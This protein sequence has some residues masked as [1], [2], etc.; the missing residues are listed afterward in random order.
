MN[1][2]W[3]K[4]VVGAAGI[5]GGLLFFGSAAANAAIPV[6]GE[7]LSAQ[8]VVQ[9][10]AGLVRP[11]GLQHVGD[12]FQ[13]LASA[14]RAESDLDAV[15]PALGNPPTNGMRVNVPQ[16]ANRAGDQVSQQ[17][18]PV[19]QK[20][21]QPVDNTLGKLP[22]DGGLPLTVAAGTT[23]DTAPT[24]STGATAPTAPTAPTGDTGATGAT[25]PAPASPIG[26]LTG[27]LT[28][29]SSPLGGLASSDGVAND[30]SVPEAR[31]TAL[32][33]SA[34]SRVLPLSVPEDFAVARGTQL[35]VSGLGSD[36][37]SL[38]TTVN[39]T[40]DQRGSMPAGS[41]PTA[42]SAQSAAKPESA[43]PAADNLAGGANVAGIPM[44]VATPT[45]NQLTQV[46]PEAGTLALPGPGSD[47]VGAVTNV[48]GNVA[49]GEGV[50]GS[51]H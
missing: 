44:N 26:G 33:L 19:T 17:A 28:G 47:P 41:I 50:P 22:E 45:L 30:A 6:A 24:A 29:G 46:Q 51:L 49:D 40:V 13:P 23:G 21:S 20:V 34:T 1:S 32:P 11:V 15:T 16:L 48:V 25:A 8:H 3:F 14:P 2:K 37:R 27:G 9:G 43:L 42:A 5:A 10:P 7:G 31:A 18:R 39:K 35:P 36:V 38:G 12:R 4:R